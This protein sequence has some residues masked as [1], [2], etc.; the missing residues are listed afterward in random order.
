MSTYKQRWNSQASF[1]DKKKSL[2]V[3]FPPFIFNKLAHAR[4]ERRGGLWK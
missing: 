2:L 3:K 1:E 4:K